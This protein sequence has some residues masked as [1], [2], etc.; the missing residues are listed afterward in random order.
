MQLDQRVPEPELMVDDAQAAAYSNA[1]FSEAHQR[2]V[3]DLVAR[4]GELADRAQLDVLD[5][6]CGPA[7]VTVRVARALPRATILGVDGSEAMLRLAADRVAAAGLDDRVR[8]EHRV[9]STDALLSGAARPGRDD[10]FDLVLSTSLLHHLADPA[11]LWQTV[12]ACGRPGAAVYVADLRR[13]PDRAAL[14]QLVAD[15]AA[16]EPQVL[17]D[18]FRNSLLASYRPDE[19]RRQIIDA[20]LDLAVEPLGER[21]LVAW[22]LV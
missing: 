5:V 7:D 15:G 17:V 9:L 18:D 16:G 10:K 8:F 1:D 13:P 19:V 6:G 2:L 3:D 14:D 21:H 22:G 11:T 4:F 12:A 20:G